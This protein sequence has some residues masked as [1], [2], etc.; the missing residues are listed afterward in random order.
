MDSSRLVDVPMY[1]WKGPVVMPVQ[2]MQRAH[3]STLPLC[4]CCSPIISLSE[5][6]SQSA[7]SLGVDA[8]LAKVEVGGEV[9]EFMGHKVT[10][11]TE[12]TFLRR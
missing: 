1:R 10:K 5:S 6:A 12:W 9:G 4:R 2:M 7:F 8:L 11:L 3:V